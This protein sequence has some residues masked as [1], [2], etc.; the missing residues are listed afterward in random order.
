[1]PIHKSDPQRL[2]RVVHN[3]EKNTLWLIRT[4]DEGPHMDLSEP[5]VAADHVL[6]AAQAAVTV[7]EYGDFECPNCKQAAP[8]V[9]MLLK[10][11]DGRVRFAYRHYPLE[12]VHAH[13]LQ[14]AEAAECAGAQ[15]KFWE[16]HQLL[17]DNQHALEPTDLHRYAEQIGLDM[18][19][20]SAEMISHVHLP[21]IRNDSDSGR[22]SGVRGTPGFFVDGTRQDVSFGLRLL[23][24]ATEAALK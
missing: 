12:Q 22:R 16:M 5:V 2:R 4:F 6:G 14:A 24:D 13:A 8:A 11:F 18:A 21:R 23:F 10:R 19:R 15:G 3:I 9:E 17:F 1:M 7:V 20:F